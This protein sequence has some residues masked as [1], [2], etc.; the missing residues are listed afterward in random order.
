MKPQS[1][2]S[3]TDA[4]GIHLWL[5]LWK[6]FRSVEAHALRHIAGLG[7]GYSDFGVLEALLHKGPMTITELGQKV[8]LTSGSMTA[9]IN[10]L[11]AKG[12]VESKE[13]AKDRRARMI[14]LTPRGKALIREAFEDHKRAMEFAAGGVSLQGRERLVDLL[15]QLGLSAAERQEDVA[16]KAGRKK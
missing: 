14:Q 4:S 11:K 6:A 9:A 13:D 8:L 12:L 10:R 5:V 7:M 16:R 1:Q 15:R 2:K 3:K